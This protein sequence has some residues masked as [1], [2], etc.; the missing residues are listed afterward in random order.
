MELE[1]GELNTGVN[2]F[3]QHLDEQIEG[4]PELSNLH[5]AFENYSMNKFS[6]ARDALNYLFGK[7]QV[8]PNTVHLRI[9][10]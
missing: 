4:N 1:K 10:M 5:D 9:L 2:L 6:D 7:S 8:N 3:L